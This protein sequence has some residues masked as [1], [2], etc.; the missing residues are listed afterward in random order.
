MLAI[1][2]DLEELGENPSHGG[3][4]INLVHCTG[5]KF[6][7]NFS[8]HT[9]PNDHHLIINPCSEKAINPCN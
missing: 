6:R 2:L 5:T 9:D 3:T 7:L 8:H 1:M 4:K